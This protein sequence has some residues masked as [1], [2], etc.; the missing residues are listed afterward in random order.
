MHQTVP[1]SRPFD[2]I[3]TCAPSQ[4]LA[5][6]RDPR[7]DRPV[8]ALLSHP[9]EEGLLVENIREGGGRT[10]WRRIGSSAGIGAG[11]RE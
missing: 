8:S 10:E 3:Q 4:I 9:S 11:G 5:S 1:S 2:G 6:F 7:Q